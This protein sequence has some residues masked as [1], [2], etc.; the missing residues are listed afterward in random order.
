MQIPGPRPQS[1]WSGG[2]AQECECV[3]RFPGDVLPL[4]R[5]PHFEKNEPRGLRIR[6]ATLVAMMS[7]LRCDGLCPFPA[8]ED[9]GEAPLAGPVK[10]V[11]HVGSRDH[12]PFLLLF[13][14]SEALAP[15]VLP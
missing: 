14:S 1:I 15:K 4:V 10:Y 6:G 9:G 8:A 11:L 13:S 2:G 3:N 7:H 12:L 5:G